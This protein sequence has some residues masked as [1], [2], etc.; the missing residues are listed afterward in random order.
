M[1]ITGPAHAVRVLESLVEQ[2]EKMI[3][4]AHP[5]PFAGITIAANEIQIYRGREYL[6]Q[7]G[8]VLATIPNITHQWATANL[9]KT[10]G[11]LIP[12]LVEGAKAAL[13]EHEQIDYVKRDDSLSEVGKSWHEMSSKYVI[14]LAKAYAPRMTEA[15]MEVPE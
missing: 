9:F 14:I 6:G 10:S 1:K 8:I 11:S 7:G 2:G 13:K 12:A 5:G 15:G 3:K 4:D